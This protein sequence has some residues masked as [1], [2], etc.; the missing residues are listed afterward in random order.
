[1][2]S[3]GPV[4]AEQDDSQSKSPTSEEQEKRDKKL[5]EI[6]AQI[7]QIKKQIEET[8]NRPDGSS[9]PSRRTRDSDCAPTKNEERLS[10]ETGNND[11]KNSPR[12]PKESRV[13]QRETI[14]KIMSF[15]NKLKEVAKSGA[16]SA[17]A[18]TRPP[19]GDDDMDEL[20]AL[21]LADGDLWLGHRFEAQEE[22]DNDLE[23]AA[24]RLQSRVQEDSHSH[25][26]ETTRKHHERSRS[27]S[28][29][30]HGDHRR[31]RE[32]SRES[33]KY[34]SSDRHRRHRH[35]DDRRHRDDG[36][37]DD[38]RHRHRHRHRYH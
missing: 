20:S 15:K 11:L 30:D 26:D 10:S 22:P 18:D 25:D 16:T 17:K 28:P 3:C 38:D 33:R 19:I 12:E 5:R 2:S 34:S 27:R 35:R 6:R 8:D 24:E 4:A 37:S 36:R 13:R 21:E 7:A 9:E 29:S 14:D 23:E 1:M 32:R 31:R